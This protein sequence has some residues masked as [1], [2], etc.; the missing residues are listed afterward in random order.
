M[1][2]VQ[3]MW[4]EYT[5]QNLEYQ[6]CDNEMVRR[7]L[8]IAFYAGVTSTLMHLA[9]VEED[10]TED[11]VYEWLNSYVGELEDFQNKLSRGEV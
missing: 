4:E 1:M 9:R 3:Q 11:R 6:K 8:K 10:L 2:T 5:S 7:N